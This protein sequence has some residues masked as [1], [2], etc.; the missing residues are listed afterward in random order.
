MMLGGKC[1]LGGLLPQGVLGPRTG[2]APNTR[3]TTVSY[4][5]TRSGFVRTL[6][7]LTQHQ[8]FLFVKDEHMDS[9]SVIVLTLPVASHTS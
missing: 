6:F 7:G 8:T 1:V 9:V 5:C 3:A 2:H 4:S